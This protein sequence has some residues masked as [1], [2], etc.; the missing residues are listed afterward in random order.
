MYILHQRVGN[1]L[2]Y[3]LPP[4]PSGPRWFRSCNVYVFIYLYGSSA[5][6]LFQ[7]LSMALRSHNQFKAR[8]WI[9]VRGESLNWVIKSVSLVLVL[10][11][12]KLIVKKPNCKKKKKMEHFC[13]L[14]VHLISKTFIIALALTFQCICSLGI[15]VQRKVGHAKLP[16][17]GL[18][19][20]FLRNHNAPRTIHIALN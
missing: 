19:I 12:W 11:R 2:H 13:Y 3:L 7:G 16:V 10:I 18:F 1:L 20:L 15:Y 6:N 17:Q 8:N 4:R 5:V 14:N 9:I